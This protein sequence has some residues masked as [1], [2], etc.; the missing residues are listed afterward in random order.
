MGGG[1]RKKCEPLL[2]EARAS[3]FSLSSTRG[4]RFSRKHARSPAHTATMMHVICALLI[5]SSS[6]LPKPEL[7][8]EPFSLGAVSL[9]PGSRL[10]D[11][12]QANSDWL[13]HLEPARLT[14]LYTSA[15][16]LTCS[17]TG[18]PYPCN[19]SESQPACTP[20]G[21]PRYCACAPNSRKAA[22]GSHTIATTTACREQTV[23]IWGTICRRRR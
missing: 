15:A 20:Y 8:V 9:T 3:R 14:C 7:K 18:T 12:A 5:A 21:H 10:H 6:A 4:S 2:F 11:Q 16:N 13:L 1:G 23:T 19:A 17:T 22:D